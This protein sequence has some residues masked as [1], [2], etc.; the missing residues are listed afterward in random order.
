[1][2]EPGLLV[3]IRREGAPELGW[4]G[5]VAISTGGVLDEIRQGS[6]SLLRRRQASSGAA[7]AGASTIIRAESAQEYSETLRGLTDVELD[8]SAGEVAVR[9]NLECA[10]L[11]AHINEIRDRG[12]HLEL[13]YHSLFEYCVKRL[14]LGEGEVYRKMQVAGA[15][16]KYPQ[17]LE[18][19]F[20]NRLHLTSASLIAPHL[21]DDNVESLIAMAQGTSKRDLAKF[22]VR[23]APKQTFRSSVR[24]QPSCEPKVSLPEKKPET[25]APQGAPPE[26]RPRDLVEPATGE[27]YNFRFSAGNEFTEKFERFA[28]VLGMESPHNHLEEIFDRAIEIA[29]DKKDPKRKLARRREREAKKETSRP[30]CPGEAVKETATKEVATR[31]ESAEAASGNRAVTRYVPSEVRERVLERAGY[32]CQYRGPDGVRCSCRIG[33]EVEHTKPFAVWRTHD[34]GCLEAFCPAHNR[35]AAEKF[36]GR[37]FIRQ[38]IEARRREKEERSGVRQSAPAP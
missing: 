22:L 29:L 13:G 5:E 14:N 28:E 20:A 19:L 32:Q 21:T 15:C 25:P 27:R 37:E 8:R 18:A 3:R 24:K 30:P 4:Q 26:P 10:R 12:Y 11:I 31:D 36:Y 23:L 35:F 38:K 34:E 1:M 16:G 6:K 7:A 2:T 33:L 9:E 17:I